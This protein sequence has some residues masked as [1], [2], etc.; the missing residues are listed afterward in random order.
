VVALNP[1]KAAVPRRV[2]LGRWV[3]SFPWRQEPIV[4]SHKEPTYYEGDALRESLRLA[5]NNRVLR[6]ASW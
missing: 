4:K 3:A 5:S 2:N 1:R 6:S